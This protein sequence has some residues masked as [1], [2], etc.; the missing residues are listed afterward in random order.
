M[1]KYFVIHLRV[2][3]AFKLVFD[4]KLTTIQNGNLNI[5]ADIL[6]KICRIQIVQNLR[7]CKKAQIFSQGRKK[8]LKIP[9]NWAKKTFK[10]TLQCLEWNVLRWFQ[11]PFLFNVN[12]MVFFIICFLRFRKLI[13]TS[14]ANC[15][16][17]II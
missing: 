1:A 16:E 5:S 17:T 10:I 13:F 4:F 8:L 6:W 2:Y 12:N 15:R 14:S 9:K 7:N 11:I 3:T